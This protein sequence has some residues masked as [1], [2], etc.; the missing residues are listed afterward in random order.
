[1]IGLD[2]NILV[3]YFTQDDQQQS[4][5]ANRLLETQCSRT[6]PGHISQI[7]LCELVWV[8]RRAYG[9]DKGP[10]LMLLDQLLLTAELDIENE[11]IARKAVAAWRDGTA[12]YSDYLVALSNQAS[13]CE[14][15]YSFDR[16]LA[17]HDAVTLAE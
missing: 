2:T 14:L 16:K 11:E 17:R 3:R 6:N 7:V 8:L 12:D 9:Y 5:V 1:V 4:E 15:T 13:G 10:L